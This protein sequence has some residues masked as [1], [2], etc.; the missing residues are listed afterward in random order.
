MK[1]GV[2]TGYVSRLRD[3]MESEDSGEPRRRR[4]E[5]RLDSAS[6]VIVDLKEEFD[7]VVAA[8]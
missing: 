5:L 7:G 1:P 2:G 6:E 3:V 4:L 8:K